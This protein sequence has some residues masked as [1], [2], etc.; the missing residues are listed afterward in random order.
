MISQNINVV[1]PVVAIGFSLS[2][3]CRCG[4][5]IAWTSVDLTSMMS[6]D[7]YFDVNFTGNAQDIFLWYK[8]DK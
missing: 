6:C 3:H 7:S 1:A 2:Y 4:T 5:A 8:F